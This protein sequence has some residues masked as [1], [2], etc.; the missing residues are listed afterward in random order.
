MK[1]GFYS[2]VGASL[3]SDSVQEEMRFEKAFKES[4]HRGV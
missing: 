2:T 1:L 3:H 4:I